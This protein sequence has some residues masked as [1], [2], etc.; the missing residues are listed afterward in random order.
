MK[1][2]EEKEEKV[3]AMSITGTRIHIPGDK[4]VLRPVH[5]GSSDRADGWH[6]DP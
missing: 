4:L 6:Q 1:R 3:P 5:I 2:R